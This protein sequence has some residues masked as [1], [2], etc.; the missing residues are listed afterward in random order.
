[1]IDPQVRRVLIVDDDPQVLETV[2]SM[3]RSIGF[4]VICTGGSDAAIALLQ[5]DRRPDV[6]LTDIHMAD[7]DGF[8]L[9]NAVR[10]QGLSIPIVAMSGGSGTM[11]ADHLELARKLGAA[12]VI[13]K[14]FRSSHL[15]EAIDRAIAGRGAPPR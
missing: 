11:D 13:D 2:A 6:I 10:E 14:P 8:E 1:M 15:A 3:L 9:I 5:D 4:E 12:A 7:G